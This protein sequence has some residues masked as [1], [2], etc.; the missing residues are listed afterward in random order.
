M[1]WAEGS[2]HTTN[3]EPFSMLD[4]GNDRFNREMQQVGSAIG[5]APM[6]LLAAGEVA[7]KGAIAYREAV[8]TVVAVQLAFPLFVGSALLRAWLAPK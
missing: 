8:R 1:P 2:V 4:T 3:R 7:L 6:P 5:I